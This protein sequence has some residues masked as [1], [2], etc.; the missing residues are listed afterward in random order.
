MENPKFGEADIRLK[1]ARE[2]LEG[3]LLGTSSR[4]LLG[5]QRLF[6]YKLKQTFSRETNLTLSAGLFSSALALSFVLIADFL[7]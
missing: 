3:M 2:F 1:E 5:S 6:V 7:N 4:F